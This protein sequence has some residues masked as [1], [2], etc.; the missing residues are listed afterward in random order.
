M[1]SRRHALSCIV[2]GMAAGACTNI[3]AKDVWPRSRTRL[4]VPYTA[5]GPLDTTARVLWNEFGALS[6]QPAIV[7]NVPGA[8][9]KIAMQQ[10]L[11]AVDGHTLVFNN[12]TSSAFSNVS[13]PK[14]SFDLLKDFKPV[15]AVSRLP[16]FLAVNASLPVESVADLARLARAQP[17]ALSYASY[18][19]G[20]PQHVVME[21]FLK[22]TRTEIVHIPYKG[23]AEAAPA[24]MNGTVQVMFV[25]MGKRAAQNPRLRV[26]GVASKER[27]FDM[28][29][30]ATLREL[31]IA[32]VDDEVCNGIYAPASVPDVDIQ[33]MNE[34]LN[35]VLEKSA[36][37]QRIMDIGYQLMGGAPAVLASRT[38]ADV[39]LF[40]GMLDKGEL[41]VL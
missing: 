36:I 9:G 38:Q 28:P 37:R 10:L 39:A 20:S 8:S 4:I 12:T 30:T 23:D 29:G 17:G 24:L 2:S 15:I 25:A 3:F 13:D 14:P 6:R 11:R 18:G 16:L 31:G 40:R 1:V 32:G 34:L 26:L 19:V 27:W 41:K 33:Q 7:D 21:N 35:A 22:A 5:G